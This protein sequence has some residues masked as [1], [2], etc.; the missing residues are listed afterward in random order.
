M[1][2]MHKLLLVGYDRYSPP[3]TLLHTS[4]CCAQPQYILLLLT[5]SCHYSHTMLPF[6]SVICTTFFILFLGRLSATEA[7]HLFTT[8]RKAANH[9]LLLR[10]RYKDEAKMKKIADIAYSVAHFGTFA[11][12]KRVR[13]EL[14]KFSDYDLHQLCV[15]YPDSLGHLQLPPEALYDSQKMQK[16]REML[17]ALAAEGHRILVFSQVVDRPYI[18]TFTQSHLPYLHYVPSFTVIH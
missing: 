8:L 12:Y 13:D 6:F 5:T 15:E 7:K 2:L 17:P 16:L 14:D 11:D 3:Y 9:P 10:V 4:C 18:L 1:L